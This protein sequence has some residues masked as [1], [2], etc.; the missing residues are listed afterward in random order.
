MRE[1]ADRIAW[2]REQAADLGWGAR[3]WMS[4]RHE[5]PAATRAR[6]AAHFALCAE[7]LEQTGCESLE[8]LLEPRSI[9]VT[10]PDGSPVAAPCAIDGCQYADLA[11]LRSALTRFV[12][13]WRADV[14]NGR[15]CVRAG[16]PASI[17][18]MKPCAI[19]V[20]PVATHGE[21]R[22]RTRGFRRHRHRPIR[23]VIPAT[24]RAGAGPGGEDERY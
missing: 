16:R 1:R 7:I 9:E 4:Q 15:P 19:A 12:E 21:N 10:A 22:R 8:E 2:Y 3:S 5:A 13:E 17:A 11:A 6:L 23:T 14:V 24:L 18:G 20:G